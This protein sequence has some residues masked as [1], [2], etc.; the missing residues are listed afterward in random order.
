MTRCWP[1]IPIALFILLTFLTT[2]IARLSPAPGVA[3]NLASSTALASSAFASAARNPTIHAYDGLVQHPGSRA[4]SG[5]VSSPRLSRHERRPTA[6]AGIPRVAVA[7]GFAAEG[8]PS[9]VEGATSKIASLSSRYGPGIEN[10]VLVNG[11]R[12]IDT[13]NGGNINVFAAR[14][15]GSGF[16][17]VTLDPSGQRIV[18]VGL[19]TA[20]NV[21][22]GIA[23]GRFVPIP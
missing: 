1:R 12:Y 6:I 13:A 3:F 2:G 19:N 8:A 23:N 4:A 9:V 14:P 21:T 20:G 7:S 17:R 16:I 5:T 22:N 15:D 11:T 10:D 18:S